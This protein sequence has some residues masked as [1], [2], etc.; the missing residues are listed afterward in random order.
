M[1]SH[2]SKKV[3]NIKINTILV[4]IDAKSLQYIS[5]NKSRILALEF[6]HTSRRRY[7]FSSQHLNDPFRCNITPKYLF[8]T[9]MSL[10]DTKTDVMCANAFKIEWTCI[11][12]VFKSPNTPERSS[13]LVYSFI[14]A[15]RLSKALR[16]QRDQHRKVEHN[17]QRLH[18]MKRV[19]SF[20]FYAFIYGCK[21]GPTFT[22][23]M[24]QCHQCNLT[25]SS[26][27]PSLCIYICLCNFI[28]NSIVFQY[29]QSFCYI[30]E[31]V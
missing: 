17:T 9:Q 25:L 15:L 3:G 29:A 10:I 26:N 6:L 14:N 23:Y 7:E 11:K 8:G 27:T 22:T 1:P 13:M 18:S 30:L 5:K 19:I 28:S 12:Q 31:G 20:S 24:G 4:Q 2:Y 21:L 16:K